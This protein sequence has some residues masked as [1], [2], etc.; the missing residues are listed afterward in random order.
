MPSLSALLTHFAGE[1]LLKVLGRL[2]RHLWVL[3]LIHL[4]LCSLSLFQYLVLSYTR[5][6]LPTLLL[7]AFHC[8]SLARQ[9]SLEADACLHRRV[10][11][12]SCSVRRPLPGQDWRTQGWPGARGGEGGRGRK[13]GKAKNHLGRN[14]DMVRCRPAASRSGGGSYIAWC[15]YIHRHAYIPSAQV[16]L[17]KPKGAPYQIKLCSSK[18][19]QV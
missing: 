2:A 14:R 7:V 17:P 10:H 4:V 18:S 1:E 12:L 6:L 13:G 19:A 15:L 16:Y 3:A 5:S 11:P 9:T 8:P